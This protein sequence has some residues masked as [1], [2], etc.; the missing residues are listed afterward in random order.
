MNVIGTFNFVDSVVNH[1]T[2]PALNGATYVKT[3]EVNGVTYVY[4]AGNTGGGIQVLRIA[5]NG[6]LKPVMSVL[7]SATV[8]LSGIVGLDVVKVGSEYFLGAIAYNGSAISMFRID[9]DGAGTDGHLIHLDNYK[10]FP[11]PGDPDDAQ[12]VMQNPTSIDGI[13]VD[14]TT[15]FVTS[16]YGSGAI[17]VYK[18]GASGTLQQTDAVVDTDKVTYNLSQS[19]TLD[20]HVIGNKTYVLTSSYGS[21]DGISVFRLTKTGKLIDVQDVAFPENRSVRDITALEINGKHY[22]VVANT[23]GYDILVYEMAANG[24]LTFLSE[25]DMNANF[26]LWD[27]RNVEPLTIDGVQFLL[28]T[29]GANDTLAV[30]SI[31]PSGAL[32]LIES[33][34]S[35]VNLDNADDIHVQKMGSRTFVL[36]TGVNGDNVAVYEIGADDD[37]LVGTKGD[38][39]IVGMNG[40]DDLVGRA[41]NDILLGGNGDDVLSGHKGADNLKGGN[42][43]DILSGGGGDDVLS[44]GDG[45]DVLIGGAGFDL[46][47]YVGSS[48]AVTVNL[49]NGQAANGDAAG[50]LFSLIEGVIGSGHDDVI[51]GDSARNELSGGNGNDVLNGAGGKDML[52][53]QGG[54]DTVNGGDGNDRLILGGGNDIGNGGN[55]N[56]RISGGAGNDRLNGGAGN[57]DLKGGGGDDWLNGGSGDDVQNGGGGADVFVFQTEHGG[58]TVEDFQVNIDK[59]DMSGHS[60]FNSFADILAGSFEFMGNTVIGSGS[61]SIQ[62]L[63]VAKADLDQNDFLF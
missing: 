9:D 32:S 20:T 40:D 58:D 45:G 48:Q 27:F 31:D 49:A 11:A 43:F 19:W 30:F 18:V 59:I 17:S 52:N 36:V 24:T 50:D 42:G 61:D 10:H 55:Q 54:K 41:G 1:A 56:D 37:P 38:D 39:R 62:V 33:I 51:T 15:F 7:D 23:S 29:S 8:E 34:T 57:D 35:S 26:S 16:T 44:G 14:G 53:G 3:I 5:A 22:V 25:T 6:K 63:D 13:Q 4:T 12:G 21:D 47:S 2:A 28:A 46:L 60:G